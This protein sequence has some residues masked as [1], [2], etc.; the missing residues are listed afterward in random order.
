MI[1]T[2]RR[3]ATLVSGSLVVGGLVSA[4]PALARGD[5]DDGFGDSLETGSK[6][7]LSN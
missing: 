3:F 6:A 7:Q 1:T 5:D 4:L 2:R